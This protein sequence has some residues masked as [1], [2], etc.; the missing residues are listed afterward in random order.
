MIICP[1]IAFNPK[2]A[3]IVGNLTRKMYNIYTDMVENVTAFYISID[4]IEY[5]ATSLNDAS[6]AALVNVECCEAK[7]GNLTL[8]DSLL[9]LGS[10]CLILE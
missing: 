7:C 9:Y 4:G 5:G 2:K 3:S 10:S 1:E 6:Y 8:D